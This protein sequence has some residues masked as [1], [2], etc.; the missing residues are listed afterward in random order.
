MMSSFT[1]FQ[2]SAVIRSRSVGRI[3][4]WPSPLTIP[5]A[6]GSVAKTSVTEVEQA[7]KSE[8]PSAP[9]RSRRPRPRRRNRRRRG[10]TRRSAAQLELPDRGLGRLPFG[11][12]RGP[13]GALG[14][15][16]IEGSSIRWPVVSV[17]PSFC[18]CGS[19]VEASP[20]LDRCSVFPPNA[21]PPPPTTRANRAAP[22][23]SRVR[24]PIPPR[25]LA[26]RAPSAA[27]PRGKLLPPGR[28]ERSGATR[29]PRSARHLRRFPKLGA[30]RG[31]ECACG[32]PL[33]ST[34]RIVPLSPVLP[35]GR[36]DRTLGFDDTGAHLEENRRRPAEARGKVEEPKA[37]RRRR[38]A[39]GQNAPL[40]PRPSAEP[41]GAWPPPRARRGRRG[42]GGCAALRAAFRS[43]AKA[44]PK[45]AL[46]RVAT[47]GRP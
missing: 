11:V 26:P 22:P 40:S 30:T 23:D 42:R 9:A 8:V 28:V 34:R 24:T 18:A 10:T 36:G 14:S 4:F 45:A 43:P 37:L 38:A 41:P 21:S 44:R 20:R 46:R 12:E 27:G 35:A 13:E 31:G 3:G 25:K 32:L 2:A 33:R 5:K 39:N 15:R 47:A 19:V 16:F 17:G 6:P 29:V 7:S 1:T